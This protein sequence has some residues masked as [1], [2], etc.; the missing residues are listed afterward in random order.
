[1]RL[2]QNLPIGDNQKNMEPVTTAVVKAIGEQSGEIAKKQAESFLSKLLDEPARALGGLFADKV[3]ARRHRNLIPVVLKAQQRL[4][5]AGLEPKAVPLKIIH[6]LLENASLEDDPEIQ[7][8]WANLLSNAANPDGTDPVHRI[9]ISILTDLTPGEAKFLRRLDEAALE[10]MAKAPEWHRPPVRPLPFGSF[11]VSDLIYNAEK[12]GLVNEVVIPNTPEELDKPLEADKKRMAVQHATDALVHHGLLQK[13]R[14]P[15]PLNPPLSQM[16]SA[17]RQRYKPE[18]IH[19]D[20]EDI[21][22]LTQLAFDFIKACST[23]STTVSKK[24]A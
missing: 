19:I 10:Q 3:N 22:D 21:Y 15:L 23:P 16:L 17:A 13:S 24:G 8:L 20:T 4:R 18:P 11:E 9:Y 7:E 6:P 5:D 2:L 12:A 1:M 14:E